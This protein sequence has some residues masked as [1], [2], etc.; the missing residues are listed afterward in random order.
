MLTFLQVVQ[1]LFNHEFS[2]QFFVS[3]QCSLQMHSQFC[4]VLDTEVYL[5]NISLLP[6]LSCKGL[7]IEF[8]SQQFSLIGSVSWVRFVR[9]FFWCKIQLQILVKLSFTREKK[10]DKPASEEIVCSLL[11]RLVSTC[12]PAFFVQINELSMLQ[13]SFTI[14]QVTIE[15]S[16]Y[17]T[18]EMSFYVTIFQYFSRLPT[19]TP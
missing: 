16:F 13:S 11:S 14:F 18:I 1:M 15:M 19:F 5:S 2:R 3:L 9:R 7:L 6:D 17:V 10:S 8:I 4:H 12:L